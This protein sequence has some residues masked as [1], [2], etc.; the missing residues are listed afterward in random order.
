MAG[1][2]TGRQSVYYKV[3]VIAGP[4]FLLED[5]FALGESGPDVGQILIDQNHDRAINRMGE[6]LARLNA[7]NPEFAHT[8]R[9]F[10]TRTWIKRMKYRKLRM[11]GL[12]FRRI[13]CRLFYTNQLIGLNARLLRK[14][15]ITG[16]S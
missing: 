11:P 14:A 5:K 13:L 1:K 2:P 12:C 3:D 7:L 16:D 8:H 15:P 9:V 6:N 10:D 4:F